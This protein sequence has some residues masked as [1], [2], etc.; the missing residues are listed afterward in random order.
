MHLGVNLRHACVKAVN[1]AV[2][3]EDSNNESSGNPDSESE[4]TVLSDFSEADHE[5]NVETKKIRHQ[6]AD[7]DC[8]VHKICKLVGHVVQS[9]HMEH[10]HLECFFCQ[11]L[12]R[13]LKVKHTSRVPK[14]YP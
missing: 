2:V 5:S 13:K 14:R 6:Y 12:Q 7:I 10:Y 1:S 9:M 3:V 8:F 11:W 4:S